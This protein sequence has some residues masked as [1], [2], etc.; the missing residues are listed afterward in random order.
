MD[1]STNTKRILVKRETRT[2]DQISP[3]NQKGN[4]M[5]IQA[6]AVKRVNDHAKFTGKTLSQKEQQEMICTEVAIATHAQNSPPKQPT[7]IMIGGLW[8]QPQ[9]KQQSRLGYNLDLD[10]ID[11]W[12][13]ERINLENIMSEIPDTSER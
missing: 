3:T 5:N 11:E 6:M 7:R 1:R 9:V 8:I 4:K 10:D 12:T 2:S 13:Q